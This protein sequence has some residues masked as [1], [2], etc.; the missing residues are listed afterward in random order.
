[1][2][3]VSDNMQGGRFWRLEDAHHDDRPVA[4]SGIE[5]SLVRCRTYV[6]STSV[7]ASTIL[8]QSFPKFLDSEKQ[9]SGL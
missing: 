8:R 2:D 4:I 5:Q 6:V 1:M 9:S 7:A 3:D